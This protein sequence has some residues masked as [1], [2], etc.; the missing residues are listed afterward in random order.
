MYLE[1]TLLKLLYHFLRFYTELIFTADCHHCVKIHQ[2]HLDN[3]LKDL[4]NICSI[5]FWDEWRKHIV[6]FISWDQDIWGV[7]IICRL[8]QKIILGWKIKHMTSL[9]RC[10]RMLL[11][12]EVWNVDIWVCNAYAMIWEGGGEFP[13]GLS[14]VI[15]SSGISNILQNNTIISVKNSFQKWFLGKPNQ[16]CSLI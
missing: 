11:Q 3:H 4:Y 16:E 13:L 12:D 14:F 8:S 10:I 7:F 6:C 9:C 2:I 1:I 5:E 15:N